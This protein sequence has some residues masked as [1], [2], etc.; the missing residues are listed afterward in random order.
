M[1]CVPHGR[2]NVLGV[3]VSPVNMDMAAAEIGRWIQEGQKHYV[4]LTGMHGVMEAVRDQRLRSV[5]NGCG[6]SLPDGMPMVWLLWRA[7][8]SHA[9]R[10]YGPDLMLTLFDRSQQA[11]YRHFL[12]GG[13]EETLDRLAGNL[14]RRF[15]AAQI[16]GRYAPPFRP[17][18]AA[19]DEGVIA[20]INAAAP[21]IVWVGLGTP[22]QDLWMARHRPLLGAAALIGVGAAFDFHAGLLRQAPRWIQRSGLEWAY[23]LGTDPVR[24]WRRYLIDNPWFLWELA[25]QKSGLKK[26]ELA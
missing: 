8:F 22:K 4:M 18:G 13:S 16:V 5:Y 10:V 1:S 26:F 7:G 9:D 19:E 11:G 24:L 20:A 25:L 23:R 21:D 15:P 6:L 12:Y 3:G 14:A 2:L 17:A